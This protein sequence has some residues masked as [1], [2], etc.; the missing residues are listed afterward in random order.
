M[1]D[2][3]KL[4]QGGLRAALLHGSGGGGAQEV[5]LDAPQQQRWTLYGIPDRPQVRIDTF[6]GTERDSDARVE[7]ERVP[8]V[9]QTTCR[10]LRKPP[11]LRIGERAKRCRYGADVLLQ[12]GIAVELGIEPDVC[13]D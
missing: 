13:A 5:G 4:H 12:L 7:I 3:G 2:A 8:A 1:T 10:R 9:R 11:P 6:V